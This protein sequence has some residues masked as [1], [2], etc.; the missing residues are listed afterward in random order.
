MKPAGRNNLYAYQARTSANRMIEKAIAEFQQDHNLTEIYHTMLHGRW[1]QCV[2][3]SA[4]S[5]SVVSLISPA[6]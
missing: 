3:Y 5:N 4:R 6:C 1:N 2:A